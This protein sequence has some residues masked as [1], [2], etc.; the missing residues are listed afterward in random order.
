L[1]KGKKGLCTIG[2]D[3]ESYNEEIL[4]SK[5]FIELGR[6]LDFESIF[7][8]EL[9]SLD[10]FRSKKKKE[11]LRMQYFN[12]VVDKLVNTT[13]DFIS[14]EKLTE[15][16]PEISKLEEA[17][18]SVR[19]KC[20]STTERIVKKIKVELKEKTSNDRIR[21]WISELEESFT[22]LDTQKK[23]EP[24]KEPIFAIGFEE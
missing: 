9:S 14:S 11:E 13:L 2:K 18:E 16:H 10:S 8:Q 7:K 5:E 24:K 12:D 20:G 17:L 22:K 23:L 15:L 4:S 21:Q 1:F 3:A 19:H 6:R